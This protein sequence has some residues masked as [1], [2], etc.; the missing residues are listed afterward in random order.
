MEEL[1]DEEIT[2]EDTVNILYLFVMIHPV[3]NPE[4]VYKHWERDK[5][6]REYPKP[7]KERFLRIIKEI[8]L[9]IVKEII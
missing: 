1:T 4:K 9:E 8:R 7:E 5:V 3:V 2:M 6:L